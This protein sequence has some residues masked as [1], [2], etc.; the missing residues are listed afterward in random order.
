MEV[1]CDALAVIE[2]GGHV[3]DVAQLRDGEGEGGLVGE[4]LRGGEVGVVER[5]LALVAPEHEEP[6]GASLGA[7]RR[8]EGRAE[9]A[10]GLEDDVAG[11][12]MGDGADAGADGLERLTSLRAATG[13]AGLPRGVPR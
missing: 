9:V 7:Q 8:V 10:D 12:L 6:D 1:V 5:G 11:R 13:R 3:L 2:Q 4:P